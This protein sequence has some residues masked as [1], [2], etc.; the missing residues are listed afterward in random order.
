VLGSIGTVGDAHDNATAESFLDSFK[1]E[2][3]GHSSPDY[4]YRLGSPTKP[5]AL[6]AEVL[7]Q[8]LSLSR[9]TLTESN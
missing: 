1:T 8:L 9:H 7:R 2:L 4:V 3:M 5:Q 6:P